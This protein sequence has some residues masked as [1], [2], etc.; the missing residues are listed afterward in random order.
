[1]LCGFDE[2]YCEDKRNEVSVGNQ[3]RS[4]T[5]GSGVG[6]TSAVPMRHVMFDRAQ[7]R[8]PKKTTAETAEKSSDRFDQM[9]L[10]FLAV[11]CP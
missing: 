7:A 2:K 9:I 5:T 11:L 6:Y 10:S 4:V 1:M 8:D 3:R